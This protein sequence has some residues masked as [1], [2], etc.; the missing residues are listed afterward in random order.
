MD[1]TRSTIEKAESA[2]HPSAP[3]KPEKIKDLRRPWGYVIKRSLRSFTTNGCTDQAAALTYFA[4]LSLFPALLAVV[5]LLGVF[6]QG[7]STTHAILDFIKPYAPDDLMSVIEQPINQLTTSGGAG[8]ALVTGVVGALWTAS[9]YVGAFGRAMNRI[10]GVVEGRPVWKLRP[11]NL[12]VTFLMVALV[13]VMM[14][15][16]LLSGGMLRFLGDVVSLGDA[17]VS[18]WSWVRWIVVVLI[19]VALITL[20]YFATPNVRQPKLRWMSPGA[21]FALVAMA[22][23]G[24]GFGLYVSN[25]GNYNATYGAIGG[26][27]VMLLFLWIMNNVLL[28]GAVLDSE[29]ERVREL[30]SGIPAESDLQLPPRDAAGAHKAL[31]TERKLEKKGKAM[32]RGHQGVDYSEQD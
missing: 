32:R 28:L 17:F 12:V 16:V 29:L 7:E 11:V 13:V 21:A 10:Y 19:A 8:F 26:V 30:Q 15:V 9:G 24:V 2:P 4:V 23:A 20:L 5:S 18:V 3:G 14:L 22:V 27:I 1:L 6:G 31:K 25:F